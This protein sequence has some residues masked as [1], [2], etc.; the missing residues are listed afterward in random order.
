M[1][2]RSEGYDIYNLLTTQSPKIVG[3]LLIQIDTPWYRAIS[4]IRSGSIPVI[5]ESVQVAFNFRIWMTFAA[6]RPEEC[7]VNEDLI[8]S[9]LESS[10]DP[11]VVRW[12]GM[13]S[14]RRTPFLPHH[15]ALM[16]RQRPYSNYPPVLYSPLV[17]A[18][19]SSWSFQVT[20]EEHSAPLLMVLIWWGQGWRRIISG[21]QRRIASTTHQIFS[22]DVVWY[23]WDTCH[24]WGSTFWRLQRN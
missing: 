17:S 8:R 10:C 22:V 9:G 1:Q 7:K 2:I 3:F 21:L 15:N 12:L 5:A 13:R 19:L 18:R 20:D 24:T 6:W 23:S 14:P 11:Y 16:P 4:R